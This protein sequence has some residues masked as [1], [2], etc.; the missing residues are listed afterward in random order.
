MGMATIMSPMAFDSGQRLS[1]WLLVGSVCSFIPLT[2]FSVPASWFMHR[3]QSYR[4][5][6]A[7]GLLPLISIIM[8]AAIVIAG[9]TFPG[10]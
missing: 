6:I 9:T 4:A 1:T 7:V 5:A 3:R 2:L 10:G 8:V